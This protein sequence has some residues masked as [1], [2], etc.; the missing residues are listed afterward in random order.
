MDC[1]WLTT[2]LWGKEIEEQ[3]LFPSAAKSVPLPMGR[4]PVNCWHQL[5]VEANHCEPFARHLEKPIQTPCCLFVSAQ[6]GGRLVL[7]AFPALLR[8]GEERGERKAEGSIGSNYMCSAEA[9]N[10]HIFWFS[11]AGLLCSFL[12]L[13]INWG[14]KPELL[15]QWANYWLAHMWQVLAFPCFHF[16]LLE[17]LL[18]DIPLG[19]LVGAAPAQEPED[20]AALIIIS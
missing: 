18:Q 9:Y 14:L 3:S 16:S 5:L 17:L 1:Q 13:S 15:F 20:Y 8:S 19:H 4:S 7:P 12:P 11:A 2:L 10:L 6:T